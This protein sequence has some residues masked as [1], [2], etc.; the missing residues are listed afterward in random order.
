LVLLKKKLI[1]GL[2]LLLGPRP[3]WLLGVRQSEQRPAPH[4]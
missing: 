2:H 3:T 4:E 1:K